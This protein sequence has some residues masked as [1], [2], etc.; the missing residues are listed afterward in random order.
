[1]SGKEI[2]SGPPQRVSVLACLALVASVC[3]SCSDHPSNNEIVRA[4]RHHPDKAV[5]FDTGKSCVFEAETVKVLEVG[6]ISDKRVWPVLLETSGS[7]TGRLERAGE[8]WPASMRMVYGVYVS[9]FD[10]L[11]VTEIEL[12]KDL[13]EAPRH[14][15]EC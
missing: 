5:L 6:S 12:C 3:T 11:D 14:L 7:C 8:T 15:S 1:M 4:F 2:R 9:D 13:G 10:S